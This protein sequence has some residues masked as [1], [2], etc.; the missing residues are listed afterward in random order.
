MTA[1]ECYEEYRFWRRYGYENPQCMGWVQD[2]INTWHILW[3]NKLGE[4]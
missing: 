3:Q 4:E 2:L 1:E